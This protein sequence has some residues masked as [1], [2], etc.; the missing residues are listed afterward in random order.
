[1]VFSLGITAIFTK[2]TIIKMSDKV[3]ERCT[4]LMEAIT[5]ENG[6]AAFKK[7]KVVIF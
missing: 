5:R 1:M 2:E 4:G 6:R 7:E 3:M